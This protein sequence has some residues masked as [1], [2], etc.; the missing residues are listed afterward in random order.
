M[1]HVPHGQVMVMVSCVKPA[2]HGSAT[3]ANGARLHADPRIA[4][5][6]S[7]TFLQ[8]TAFQAK[9]L[10]SAACDLL[11]S[12]HSA[13]PMAAQAV[14]AAG[15]AV[16]FYFYSQ[17]SS[18]RAL[19]CGFGGDRETLRSLG[20]NPARFTNAH[21]APSTWMEALYFFAEALRCSLQQC[22]A[23]SGLVD[24]AQ[25]S[26]STMHTPTVSIWK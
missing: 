25:T 4:G 6:S 21:Q 20:A 10:L 22:T 24:R 19:L 26:S 2:E 1:P 12:R 16:V 11:D 3:I 7:G 17:R 23:T 15:A 9:L 14:A 5:F 18:H 13:P 8:L